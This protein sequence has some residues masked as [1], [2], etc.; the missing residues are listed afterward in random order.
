VKS[1][2]K[3]IS[4]QIVHDQRG[5]SLTE[6]LVALGLSSVAMLLLASVMIETTNLSK[7]FE[8]RA[9]DEVERLT[10]ERH[11]RS[12]FL[13]AEDVTLKPDT[14]F[15]SYSGPGALIAFDSD[16]HW[17]GPQS[18]YTL[19]LF[20]RDASVSLPPPNSPNLAP[21]LAS[22]FARTGIFFQMPTETTWGVL[23]VDLGTQPTVS[24]DKSDLMFEGLV[25][26]KFKN[27]QTFRLKDTDPMN[28]IN[29]PVT[30]LDIEMTFRKFIN[31][32]G[33]ADFV[34][35]PRALLTPSASPCQERTPSRDVTRTLR[36]LLRNNV[37]TISPSANVTLPL[38]TGTGATYGA[39]TLDRI[40]FFKP[41]TPSGLL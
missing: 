25:G 10:A 3:R 17:A 24:P 7:S 31:P 26:L 27:V 23:Y 12:I 18:V 14:N 39:R 4:V 35:C 32:K 41:Y 40:H 21:G 1:L 30:S 38:P 36:V 6:L 8:A 19:A 16:A 33:Q 13:Q 37:L 29:S 34:F 9:R 22:H 20:W 11:L 28:A 5:M 2:A 15:N